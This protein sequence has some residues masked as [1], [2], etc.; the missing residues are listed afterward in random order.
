[1][2][3]ATASG[4]RRINLDV[5]RWPQDTFMGRFK[6]FWSITDWRNGLHSEKTLNE[7]KQLLDLYR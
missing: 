2:S 4:E 6:H 7:S 1:M 3:D 5:P